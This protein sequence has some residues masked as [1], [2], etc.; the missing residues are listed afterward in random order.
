[1]AK[2]N[3]SQQKKIRK[4]VQNR[5][6]TRPF[7][8]P[9][10]PDMIV[11]EYGKAIIKEINKIDKLV[12]EILLPKLSEITNTKNER[13]DSSIRVDVSQEQINKLA[14][15]ALVGAL[16][17]KM[18]QIFYGEILEVNEEPSQKTFAKVAKRI[19]EPFLNRADKFQKDKF[20]SEFKRQTGTEPIENQLNVDKFVNDATRKNVSLIKTIPQQY[21]G[22]IQTV[23]ENAVDRGQLTRDVKKE[24]LNIN[25]NNKTR[26]RLV[27]RD[28]VA[29][30]TGV[31]NEA[32]QRQIGVEEYIWRTMQDQRV[33]SFSNTS[34]ASDHERLN[35]TIQKWSNPPVTVFSGKRAGERH[36]PGED[37]ACRCL[38]QPVY[39]KITGI[40]HPETIEARKKTE[41]M[42]KKTA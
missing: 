18:K 16:I 5:R 1:M 19:A 8:G 40:D 25:G 22:Q 6:V 26:A 39:D 29:K 15:V 9:D 31:I 42:N 36:H 37:I 30:L 7:E 10:F 4:R 11:L 13:L 2:V 34:G 35:G 33:R 12:K 21:F 23:V 27:A 20:V 17:T 24:L 41:K 38:A 3:R 32:R 14:G 28:Q